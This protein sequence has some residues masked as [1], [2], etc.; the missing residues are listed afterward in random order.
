MNLLTF[1]IPN[2]YY[3]QCTSQK[4]HIRGSTTTGYTH[5]QPFPNRVTPVDERL[6]LHTVPKLTVIRNTLKGTVPKGNNA[7]VWVATARACKCRAEG[8]VPRP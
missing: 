3:V 5:L 7:L 8:L 2:A 6:H 1:K 4:Y